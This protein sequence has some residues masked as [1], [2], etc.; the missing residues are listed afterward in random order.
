M[1]YVLFADE[2]NPEQ[3]DPN[4]FFIY[5]GLIVPTSQMQ[6]IHS[7]IENLRGEAGMPP[8]APLKFAA[9]ERPKCLTADEHTLLK[10]RVYEIALRNKVRFCGYAILH[11]IAAKQEPKTLV[12]WGADILLAKFNQFLDEESAKGW[13]NFDRINTSKPFRYLQDKFS[14]RQPTEGEE[15][16]LENIIGYGFTCD[17]ASHFASMADIVI[18]GFRYVVNEPNRDIAGK[19]IMR[20]IA[21]IM[22]HRIDK[23]GIKQVGGRGLVLRPKEVRAPG[24]L[25]EYEEVRL[26]LAAWAN[27]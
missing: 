15:V 1:E 2:A 22:W 14:R 19:S 10:Q 18:G 7:A 16:Y 26:R 24:Y 23:D 12:E 25:A 6:S 4:K 8:E 9:A 13:V 5:G 21:S 20:A 11:A 27:T 17:G 3:T